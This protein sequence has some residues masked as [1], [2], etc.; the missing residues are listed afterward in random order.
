MLQVFGCFCLRKLDGEGLAEQLE[1][2][3]LEWSGR[4]NEIEGG[5]VVLASD[6]DTVA[7]DVGEVFADVPFREFA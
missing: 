5:G 4:G 1:G 6:V 7:G 2:A 3:V